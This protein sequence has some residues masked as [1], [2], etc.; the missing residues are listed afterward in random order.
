MYIGYPECELEKFVS[1]LKDDINIM[2][3]F[4]AKKDDPFALR[5]IKEYGSSSSSNYEVIL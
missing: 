3:I 4:K 1:E 2:T 5:I